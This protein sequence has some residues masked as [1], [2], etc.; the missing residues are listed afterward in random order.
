MDRSLMTGTLLGRLP[1]VELPYDTGAGHVLVGKQAAAVF[2]HFSERT[3]VA[4]HSHGAQWGAVLSG[5]MLLE[6][7][8][9]RTQLGPGDW[10]D[11]PAGV[12]HGAV[13]EAGTVLIDL[14]D[15]PDRF[16]LAD[17]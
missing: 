10:Y 16:P 4:Q 13:V 11:I 5:S 3:E 2:V 1:G 9:V 8:G 12:E 14:F 15:E 6:L 17:G 7:G